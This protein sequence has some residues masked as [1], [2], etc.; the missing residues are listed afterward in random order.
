MEGSEWRQART[1]CRWVQLNGG[2]ITDR[3]E[4]TKEKL[5]KAASS[6]T[7]KM[8]QGGTSLGLDSSSSVISDICEEPAESLVLEMSPAA[9]GETNTTLIKSL[10]RNDNRRPCAPA[11]TCN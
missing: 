9:V 6:E 2:I 8:K 4:L 7:N 11:T 1:P 10:R 3:E 5:I